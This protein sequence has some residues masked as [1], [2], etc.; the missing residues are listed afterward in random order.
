M[1]KDT[2]SL[3]S[4]DLPFQ[5]APEDLKMEETDINLSSTNKFYPLTRPS[6]VS[7]W[8][9]YGRALCAEWLCLCVT[10]DT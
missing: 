7:A 6:Q 1:R 8:C 4:I 9:N 2:T 5:I 10:A 3:S